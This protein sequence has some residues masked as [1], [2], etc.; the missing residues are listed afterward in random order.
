MLK[1][2]WNAL[3]IGLAALAIICSG[4]VLVPKLED[5]I[6]ELAV[7]GST[8]VEFRRPGLDQHLRR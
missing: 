3:T 8:T 4:C 5:K 2:R 1:T 6:V 7:G